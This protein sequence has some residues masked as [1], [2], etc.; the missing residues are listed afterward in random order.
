MGTSDIA[1]WDTRQGK[2]TCV[3]I[4][5]FEVCEVPL[6]YDAFK[7]LWVAIRPHSVE[8]KYQREVVGNHN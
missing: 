8:K 5:T 2:P 1:S 4:V 7:P 3:S 6:V